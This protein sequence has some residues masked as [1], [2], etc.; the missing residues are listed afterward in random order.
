MSRSRPQTVF[1]IGAVNRVIW[2]ERGREAEHV[3]V[4]FRLL[5]GCKE[6]Y[7]EIL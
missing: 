5:V 4:G 3:L 2:G 7:D 1:A 6:L